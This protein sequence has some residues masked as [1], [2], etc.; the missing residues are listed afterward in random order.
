MKMKK[1]A[2]LLMAAVFM[3][4]MTACTTQ[5]ET[6][7]AA[8]SANTDAQTAA[9]AEAAQD[10]GKVYTVGICQLVQHEALDAAT[11]GFKDALTEAFGENV[12]F[13]E[14]NASN[15]SATCAT[16][17]NQFVASKV[18]LIMANATPALQAAVA[19]TADIPI[20]ATSITDY[21]TALDISDWTGTTGIN[22]TGT[23]DLAP[24]AE[25]AAMVK[26]LVPEAKTVGILYC[27]AEPNSKYQ[28]GV[29]SEELTAMGMQVKDYT[30]ADSND[31][32][33]V[34]QTAVEG[35]DVLY[36]PTDNTV[37][38]NTEIINGV[39]EDAGIPI[40][41]GEEGICKGCGIATLSIDYYSIGYRAGEMAADILANGADPA[42]MEIDFATEL[43]KKVM[44][45]RCETLG[46]TVPEGYEAIAE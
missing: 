14:Q 4:S 18:D 21:A 43:T 11:Q 22:V 13:D 25:Q 39:A 33:Q 23:A 38:S 46:I 9:G 40:I 10:E 20:V 1:T 36:V 24:L 27:S 35:C 37:A 28:A 15:D 5:K 12:V 3:L 45:S 19:S 44:T 29:V 17:V 8:S 42:T 30:F 6:P 34:T 31:V 7:A 32:M 41:A 2:A 16:I 26:E